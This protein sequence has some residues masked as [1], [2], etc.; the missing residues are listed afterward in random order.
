MYGLK[1]YGL[2]LSVC[3]ALRES[4]TF[5]VMTRHGNMIY[6]TSAATITQLLEV[7]LGDKNIQIKGLEN[8]YWYRSEGEKRT[9]W[10][11]SVK[12]SLKKG[13][14]RNRDIEAKERDA[15]KGRKESVRNE[16]IK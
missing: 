11:E 3:H 7:L 9:K 5:S 10:K 12:T 2:W 1:G 15:L 13:W 14:K 16:D 8:E 4:W 6:F